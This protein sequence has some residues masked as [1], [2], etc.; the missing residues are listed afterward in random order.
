MAE[1]NHF[2]GVRAPVSKVY[3]ALTTPEGLAKWWTADVSGEANRGGGLVKFR[4]G[5]HGGPDMRVEAVEP[6]TSVEWLCVE[7]QPG[8]WRNTRFRFELRPGDGQVVIRFR[9]YDWA[10]AGDF[11]AFCST[12]W[13]TFLLSLRESVETG[14][15]RPWPH[16]LQI[17]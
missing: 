1:I 15:G 6:N 2:I 5:D 17:T 3:E 13:A 8:D 11:L 14:V 16:D 4:F 12:K 10:E 9:H 7:H